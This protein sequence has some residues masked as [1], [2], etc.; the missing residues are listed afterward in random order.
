MQPNCKIHSVNNSTTGATTTRC[1]NW[2]SG[3]ISVPFTAM[4]CSCMGGMSPGWLTIETIY[5]NGRSLLMY[6]YYFFFSQSKANSRIPATSCKCFLTWSHHCYR[7]EDKS[8]TS[9]LWEHR[10]WPAGSKRIWPPHDNKTQSCHGVY[11]SKAE[12]RFC[13]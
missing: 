3:Y 13:S 9:I 2:S 5:S 8:C 12:K 1:N 11:K 6:F 4:H 7:K 10:C